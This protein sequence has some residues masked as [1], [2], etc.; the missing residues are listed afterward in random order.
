MPS[1]DNKDGQS[2]CN[3]S[4]VDYKP[5]KGPFETAPAITQSFLHATLIERPCSLLLLKIL[6]FSDQAWQ[7]CCLLTES[8]LPSS[9][10]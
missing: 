7:D 2:G 6:L 9:P 4:R 10:D 1:L 8:A 3:N 5:C